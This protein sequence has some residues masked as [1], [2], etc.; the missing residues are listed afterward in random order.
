MEPPYTHTY[1]LVIHYR[2][3]DDVVKRICRISRFGC[4]YIHTI[5]QFCFA[6]SQSTFSEIK[7][8][9]IFLGNCCSSSSS[10]LHAPLTSTTYCTST[11][12]PCC[13]TCKKIATNNQKLF[14]FSLDLSLCCSMTKSTFIKSKSV[15]PQSSTY[16]GV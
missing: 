2:L 4:T 12:D 11:V 10:S 13:A 14:V 7:I 8:S 1:L 15:P 3:I 5:K 9:Q 6:L 16:I